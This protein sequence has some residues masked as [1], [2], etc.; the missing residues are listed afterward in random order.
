MLLKNYD[1]IGNR[2]RDLPKFGVIEIK[3]EDVK[4]T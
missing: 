1:I 3:F 2:T 4:W